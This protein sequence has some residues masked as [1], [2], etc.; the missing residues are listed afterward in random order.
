MRLFFLLLSLILL[1]IFFA[2]QPKKPLEEDLILEDGCLIYALHYK[3][4]LKAGEILDASDVWNKLI[5][6]RV[7]GMDSGH[8]VVLYIH[9]QVSFVY[10][11]AQGSFQIAEFP[12]Y[13][14]ERVVRALYPGERVIWAR[15]GETAMLYQMGGDPNF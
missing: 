2:E 9:E 5:F 7:E 11:P 3:R 1:F 14:P 15:Y 8:A 6:F 4:A 13:S 12:I 10:D